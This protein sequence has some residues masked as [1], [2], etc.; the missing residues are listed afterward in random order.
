MMGSRYAK[1]AGETIAQHQ[2]NKSNISYVNSYLFKGMGKEETERVS[3][4]Q[5]QRWPFSQKADEKGVMNII[6]DPHIETSS[7]NIVVHKG[8]SYLFKRHDTI[9]SFESIIHTFTTGAMD[10]LCEHV[11]KDFNGANAVEVTYSVMEGRASGRLTIK[12][13]DK[14]FKTGGFLENSLIVDYGVIASDEKLAMLDGQNGPGLRTV[15]YIDGDALR[16]IASAL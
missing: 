16:A 9:S 5:T 1:D 7:H 12:T 3:Y 14:K 4:Q 11:N 13:V 8:F 6:Y 2:R 10:R 15:R